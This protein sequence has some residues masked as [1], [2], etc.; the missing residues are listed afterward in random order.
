MKKTATTKTATDHSGTNNNGGLDEPI[1][2]RAYALWQQRGGE[3]GDDLADW[4][5]AEIE[6]NELYG[7]E[8]TDRHRKQSR[9]TSSNPTA[10]R[11]LA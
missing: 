10:R 1:A 3:H 6:V 2:H 11:I 7:E 8:A 4:F 5:Q 9:R